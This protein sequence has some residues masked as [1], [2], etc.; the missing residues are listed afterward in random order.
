M[1]A[2]VLMPWSLFFP[3]LNKGM[4]SVELSED[5]DVTTQLVDYRIKVTGAMK[6]YEARQRVRVSDHAAGL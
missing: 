4:S 6:L 5:F 3:R 1:G 2:A